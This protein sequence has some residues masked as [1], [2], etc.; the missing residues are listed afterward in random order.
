MRFRP[1]K[2]SDWY[3]LRSRF[4]SRKKKK[5]FRW[6]LPI[7]GNKTAGRSPAGA[8][9]VYS[10]V[11][12]LSRKEKPIYLELAGPV[13][14]KH[15]RFGRKERRGRNGLHSNSNKDQVEWKKG[16]LPFVP[17]T[18]IHHIFPSLIGFNGP[19]RFPAIFPLLTFGRKEKSGPCLICEES[20]RPALI[21]RRHLQADRHG[22]PAL[23]FAAT[24]LSRSGENRPD[25]FNLLQ[26]R[27]NQEKGS[28]FPS[29][30]ILIATLLRARRSSL[31]IHH[32]FIPRAPWD[33]LARSPPPP[34]RIST[35]PQEITTQHSDEVISC[36]S[37]SLFR[38]NLT[39]T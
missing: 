38:T 22:L 29:A 28:R 31:W 37:N 30:L 39:R 21:N 6:V 3:L 24:R 36:F 7:N 17:F 12:K 23:L 34:D 19:K 27:R 1:G 20:A 26:S 11:G 16:S 10:D 2:S 9:P 13:Q 32:Y 25:W 35:S 15:K 33:A 18:R 4:C 8:R 5:L 14:R